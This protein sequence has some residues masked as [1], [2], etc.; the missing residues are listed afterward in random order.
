MNIEIIKAARYI[1]AGMAFIGFYGVAH[2]LSNAITSV[3]AGIAK[4]PNAKDDLRGIAI[5]GFS[6]IELC[7]L[8]CFAGLILVLIF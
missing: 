6:M 1:A 7:A 8:L 2:G 4:N 5:I 3:A